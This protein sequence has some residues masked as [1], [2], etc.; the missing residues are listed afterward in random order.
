MTYYTLRGTVAIDAGGIDPVLSVL[1]DDI[2]E[3][4]GFSRANDCCLASRLTDIACSL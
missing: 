2:D 1:D 3:L 4:L